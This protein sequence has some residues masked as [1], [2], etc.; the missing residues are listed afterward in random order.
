MIRRLSACSVLMA[1]SGLSPHA[2]AAQEQTI[3][4]A[5]DA[6]PAAACA[7]PVLDDSER[8]DLGARLDQRAFLYFDS[9]CSAPGDNRPLEGARASGDLPTVAVADPVEAELET[10]GGPGFLIGRARREVLEILR[11]GNSCSVW[12]AGA[13]RDLVVKF[14]SLHFRVDEQGWATVLGEFNSGDVFF[15]EPYVAR[16][17]ES[18]GRGSIITLNAHGAFFQSRAL[19]RFRFEAG[20]PFLAQPLK[21][22]HVADYPGGSLNAQVTT[23]LHEFGHIVGILPIDSGEPRSALLS[24]RNTTTLLGHCRKQIEASRDRAILLPVALAGLEQS[25]REP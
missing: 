24:T 16:T 22:L 19:A 3:L 17:Q 9:V 25:A 15:R 7:F 14:A 11:E 18:V 4:R 1:L 21:P 2:L 20:G 5:A 8:F 13:E 23:L 6:P 12:F 10:M